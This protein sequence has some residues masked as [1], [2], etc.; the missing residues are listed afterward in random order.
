MKINKTNI[1]KLLI[2]IQDNDG[3][4]LACNA[5]A[6]KAIKDLGLRRLHQKLTGNS[7]SAYVLRKSS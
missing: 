6:T 7:D 1:T 3:L 5:I 2:Q 4:Q